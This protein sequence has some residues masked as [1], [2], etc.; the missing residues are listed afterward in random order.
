MSDTGLSDRD[1]WK[2]FTGLIGT[3]AAVT[4]ALFVVANSIGAKAKRPPATMEARAIAERIKPVGEVTIASGEAALNAMSSTANAA[5]A[6]ESTYNSACVA[7]H[8]AGIAG[9]PKV[10]DKGAW[11]PRI[12]KGTPALYTNAIKGFTGKAGVMPPKG[13]NT[14]LKDDDVKAAVD[15]MVG[16]S[17]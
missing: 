10:G 17:K 5:G 11:A 8:G 9:A 2:F 1:F 12:A 3:L 15:F 6:G 14:A 13:G 4:V 16:K 7:C